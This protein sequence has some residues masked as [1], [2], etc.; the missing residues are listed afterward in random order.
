GHRH[1]EV[2]AD[3]RLLELVPI[4]RFTGEMVDESFKEI[5]GA[6]EYWR[7]GIGGLIHFTAPIL[8]YS[9]ALR[10]G[11]RAGRSKSFL[12]R[13]RIPFTKRPDSPPPNVFSNLIA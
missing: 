7:N 6:V 11:S 10:S 1:T 12:T 3:Q 9:I 13:S 5:H 4:N 8:H 2:R